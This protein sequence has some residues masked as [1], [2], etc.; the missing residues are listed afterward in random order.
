[1]IR[2]FV[3]KIQNVARK[4]R[5]ESK[6]EV[7]TTPLLRD[8]LSEY[9][10]FYDPE[11]NASLRSLGFSRTSS[12]RPDSLFGSVVLDY[13]APGILSNGLEINQSKKQIE[14]YLDEISL[15][16]EGVSSERDRLAGI[17]FDGNSL[18]FCHSANDRW[19]WTPVYPVSE[20]SLTTLVQIYRS[21]E[22]D[23]LSSTLLCKYFGKDSDTARQVV[24]AL[25]S[26]L[27]NP[28]YKTN[29]LFTEWLRLFEQSASYDY[30]QV[31]SL[32]QV[33][34][35][36]SSQAPSSSQVLF[37]LHTYYSI[38]VKLLTAELLNCVQ[39]IE[40][41][42]IVSEI[43][44]ATSFPEV[45]RI[46]RRLED[47]DFYKRYRIDNFLEG[48]FFSWYIDEPSLELSDALVNIAH[49]FSRFEPA[50]PKLRPE[51]MKDLLKEFYSGIM[52]EQIR[53][54]IGEY[55]TPDW[56]AQYVL[57]QVGYVGQIGKVCCDPACGSNIFQP[58]VFEHS[59]NGELRKHR[60]I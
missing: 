57:Q 24:P 27:S 44:N 54:D 16:Q 20:A 38:I 34:N 14:S 21:L 51:A 8:L 1:M 30:S 6:L 59:E 47:G 13:K 12:L 7:E 45:F 48:D 26:A 42:P 29:M 23:R 41:N 55:Y 17:L 58:N 18:V 31:P 25:L 4:A 35:Q 36:L 50:T 19:R 60:S 32:Q 49:V 43:A 9:K 39:E 10:V 33:A 22:K 56:L 15:S 46:F 5:T 28:T 40:L 37:A 52:D 53:H 11:I 3:I 2:D